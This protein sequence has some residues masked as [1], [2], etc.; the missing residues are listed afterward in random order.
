MLQKLK[1]IINKTLGITEK[2]LK[3][4]LRYPLSFFS[5]IFIKPFLYK[6]TGCSNNKES[7]KAVLQKDIKRNKTERR[8]W[9]PVRITDTGSIA[10]MLYHGSAHIN[11]YSNADGLIHLKKGV[12]ELKAGSMV[13]VILI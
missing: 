6:L 1:R 10:T 5:Y 2:E 7:I 12:K 4:K 13:E 9:L 8:T 3:L 11:A